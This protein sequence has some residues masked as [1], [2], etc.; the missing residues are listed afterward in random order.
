[1]RG[2]LG[3]VCCVVAGSAA[4]CTTAAVA[5]GATRVAIV[6]PAIP[7]ADFG[8]VPAELGDHDVWT[9]LR[10]RAR[11]ARTSEAA[12]VV[13]GARVNEQEEST[14]NVAHAIYPVIGESGDRIRVVVF[15]DSAGIALW[16]PRRDVAPTAMAP[17]RLGDDHGRAD[18]VSGVTL[19]A[20]VGLVA[21][22]GVP[23]SEP[24]ANGLR[25]VK[26]VD[27]FLDATGYAPAAAIGEVWVANE[28][29]RYQPDEILS[30]PPPNPTGSEVAAV[31]IRE[32]PRDDAPVVATAKQPLPVRIVRLL[33]PWDE[34][35]IHGSRVRVHGFVP[36]AA[37]TEHAEPRS[38]TGYGHGAGYGMSD[39]IMIDVPDAVC[40]YDRDGGD[41]I[42]V[43]DGAKQRYAHG[44]SAGWWSVVV[45]TDWGLISVTIHDVSEATDPRAASW[46][47]CRK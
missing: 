33:G 41:V 1:M 14:A 27:A 47:T 13:G 46:E 10:H 19:G 38:Y 7:Q 42:G 22:P 5:G 26:L 3:V 43:E 17:V 20:G 36:V 6:A 21:E 23:G 44:G 29:E 39:T 2:V 4:S 11:V 37:V 30:E 35:E 12:F 15:G 32:A 8:V 40:L 28:H 31:T 25:K 9:R 45:G 24:A 18:A 34:I 16:I